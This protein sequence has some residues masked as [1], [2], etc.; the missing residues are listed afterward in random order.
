MDPLTHGIT[1]ALLGKGLFSKR[2]AQQRR[3][4][5]VAI[6]SATLGAVF[7]DVDVVADAFSSDPM[8]IVRFHRNITHSFV[9]L[10]VW[11]VA[12]AWLTRRAARWLGFESPSWAMLTL[13]YAVGI[14]SHIFLDGMTSFGTRIWA[15]IREE[16][17]AW[18]LLFIIDFTFT[19][20][21]LTP[22]FVAWVYSRKDRWLGRAIGM[23]ALCSL[24]AVAAWW[25]S[26]SAS[27]S[28]HFSIVV[29]ASVVMAA[30]FFFPAAREWGFRFT[31]AGWCQAGILVTL[32]YLFACA[33]AHHAAMRR[34]EDFASANHIQIVRIAAI[35]VPP[36]LLE[37][38]GEIRTPDGVYQAH[39]DLRNPAP[40]SFMFFA[41]SPPD[42]YVS[43]AMQMRDVKLYWEFARFPVIRTLA[44]PGQHI[45][46]FSEHRFVNRVTNNPP[47]FTYRVVF[48]D[49]GNRV[50]E[51]WYSD[52]LQVRSMRQFVR[53]RARK[54]SP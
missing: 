21:V 6:F 49:S 45:V 14:A 16:R 32:V 44:A 52:G 25:V 22:Q 17:V 38:G 12:L 40:P 10:P 19:A 4:T 23:W 51:G 54:K 13:I 37:W 39:F 7:P 47:P 28:F 24:G 27:Y 20:I 43:R 53:S 11:A 26:R 41:D 33:S 46:E 35:P 5:Q 36:S 18:D 8:A 3:L 31:R 1:G 2:D 48:D 9:C 34:V 42:E 15:P 50:A 30:L 29:A